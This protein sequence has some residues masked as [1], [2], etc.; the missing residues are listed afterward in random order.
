MP[1]ILPGLPAAGFQLQLPATERT[2]RHKDHKDRKITKNFAVFVIFCGLRAG[3]SRPAKADR[4]ARSRS[5][6]VEK[7]GFLLSLPWM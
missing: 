2:L 7:D 5:I 4:D 6:E 3:A 1:D